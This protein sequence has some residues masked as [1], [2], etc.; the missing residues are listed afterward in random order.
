ME[1]KLKALNLGILSKALLLSILPVQV[2][3]L[4]LQAISVMEVEVK[5]LPT[6][7]IRNVK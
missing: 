3:I 4:T 6:P 5:M 1:R 2:N 7:L